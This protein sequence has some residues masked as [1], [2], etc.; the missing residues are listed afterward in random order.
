MRNA[1]AV[2]NTKGGVGKSTLVLALAETL[3]SQYRKNVLVIDSDAQA[4]VS[5]MLMTPTNLSKLQADGL[6]IV[7]YLVATVLHG[8][9][10]EWPRFVVRGVSDVDDARTVFLVPSD[11]QL[12]LFEREVSREALHGRLRTAI[13]T[14]LKQVREVFDVVLIDCPPGLS[15]LTESWLREADFHVSPTKADY[16]SA[17]GLEVFRRFKALNPEMGF[18]ENLGVLVTMKDKSSPIEDEYHH[19]L[20]AN[21]ENRCFSRAIPRM[22]AMQ[23]AAR[24]QTIERSYAAKY[25]GE[26]GAAMRE[27]TT[28]L[29]SRLDAAKA[30][31]PKVQAAPAVAPVAA[32]VQAPQHRSA[33]PAASPSPAAGLAPQQPAP[34]QARVVAAQPVRA[35]P[36]TARPQ[37][38]LA[39]TTAAIRA[40]VAAPAAPSLTPSVRA[41]ATSPTPPVGGTTP[42]PLPAKSQV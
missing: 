21:P 27:L 30:A 7:D 12:T 6:T 11:M 26:A 5:S 28:E 23:D 32:P 38:D 33:P 22:T 19:W 24:F 37:A 15:V 16:I 3:S 14:M 25:P 9:P 18:A 35:A 10:T 4:S 42:P 2:M 29:M 1:I 20:A 8:Q 31:A 40:A 36:A 41:Q 34:V 17:C 13:A 39:V